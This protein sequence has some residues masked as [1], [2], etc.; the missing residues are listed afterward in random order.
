MEQALAAAAAGATDMKKISPMKKSAGNAKLSKLAFGNSILAAALTLPAAHIAHAD[1][2]PERGMISFKHLDYQDSQPGWDRVGVKADSVM[3]MA[4]IAGQWSIEGV[5]TSDT[6]S[7]ASPAYHSQELGSGIMHDKRDS[8]DI[9]IT[10]YFSQGALTVGRSDSSESDYVSQVYSVTGSVST[11]DKNTTFSLGLGLTDDMINAPA[12]NVLNQP[13]KSSDVMLG[14]TRVLSV[15]DIAQLNISHAEGRG[16]YSDPYKFFDN[17]PDHKSQT[18]VLARWNHH[19]PQFDGTGRFSYRYYN[20]SF[21]VRAHTL[22]AEYVQPLSHGWTVIPEIRLHSQEAA[23]FYVDPVNPPFPTI[24]AGF[25]PGTTILSQD[26][27]LSGFGAVTYG[28]KIQYQPNRDWLL[29]AEFEQY[30]QR[31]KWNLQGKGSPGIDPFQ[32]RIL[33]VGITRYF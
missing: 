26:Q 12:A 1:T 18:A 32:A 4:P 24:P 7:G 21:G 2:A 14:I 15:H 23:S 27:R 30:E 9:R 10:R 28:I 31:G 8:H 16:Y 13:K 17:R 5:L 11:E 33:Q 19:F 29:D 25:I 6:V 20:D 3:F 22:G